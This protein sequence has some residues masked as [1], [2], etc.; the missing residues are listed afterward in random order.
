MARGVPGAIHNRVG[1]TA[2]N[3]LFPAPTGIVDYR[4]R[5]AG[6]RTSVSTVFGYGALGGGRIE[7]DSQ[8]PVVKGRLSIAMG[9]AVFADEYASGGDAFLASYAIAPC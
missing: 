7:V 9:A 8:I 4:V 1:L 6:D 5:P 2:Q 3:Y